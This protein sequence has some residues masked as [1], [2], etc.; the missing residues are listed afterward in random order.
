MEGTE[1]ERKEIEQIAASEARDRLTEIVDR[2][3]Y[4]GQRTVITRN[5]KA[6][7]AVVSLEDLAK[8]ERIEAEAA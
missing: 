3:R 7:A 5:G 6:T 1:S 4:Q 8:L 2:A